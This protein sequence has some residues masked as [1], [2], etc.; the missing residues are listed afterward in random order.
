MWSVPCQLAPEPRMFPG[1]LCQLLHIEPLQAFPLVQLIQIWLSSLT[2]DSF[3]Y[4]DFITENHLHN[5]QLFWGNTHANPTKPHQ[6]IPVCICEREHYS[7]LIFKASMYRSWLESILSQAWISTISQHFLPYLNSITKLMIPR[8]IQKVK[9]IPHPWTCCPHWCSHSA[10]K[11]EITWW[12]NCYFLIQREQGL[13]PV[14]S[15]WYF[16][17]TRNT[18][19]PLKINEVHLTRCGVLQA[20]ESGIVSPC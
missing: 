12:E 3:T 17:V 11:H 8:S 4:E 7:T 18:Q 2:R 9:F 16:R 13:S 10:E 19:A 14:R 5:M 1:A 15:G 6:L 20:L